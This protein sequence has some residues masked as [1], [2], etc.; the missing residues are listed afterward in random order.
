MTILLTST[1]VFY[2]AYAQDSFKSLTDIDGNKYKSI[3][4]GEQEWMAENLKT[5]KLNDGFDIPNVTDMTQW[6]RMESPAYS[7]Y[8]NNI[9]NKAVYG[10]LY[11]WHAV[12]TDKLCPKGWRV[13]T[14]NDWEILMNHLGSDFGA[15]S[16]LKE[17]DFLSVVGGYRYGYYW[18]SGIFYEIDVNGYWWTATKCT[19]THVWSR[20]INL[21]K[22]KI[23]RS[24]FVKS[25]GFA[26]RC[27]KC[28]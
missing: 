17:F 4:I 25:N 9:S 18:G 23:Y 6:V 14:D 1:G 8:D 20:T 22:S 5:T 12:N 3:A 27:I 19:D 13:P 24:Y 15:V 21:K 16:K 2:N 10:G 7:W 11:N 26:V 28:N